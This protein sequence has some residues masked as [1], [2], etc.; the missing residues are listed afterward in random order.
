M[1]LRR[2]LCAEGPWVWVNVLLL[3]MKLLMIIFSFYGCTC[4]IWKFPGQE[5][6]LNCSGSDA[7]SLNPLFSSDLSCC[8]QIL[9][10]LCHGGKS[11]NF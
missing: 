11:N 10:L 7:G 5:L 1:Q 3:P 2:P 4:G 6:H 9:N 8:S